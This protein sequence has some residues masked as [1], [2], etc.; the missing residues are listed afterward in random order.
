MCFLTFDK[1]LLKV[2]SK[3]PKYNA[4]VALR[5]KS[6]FFLSIYLLIYSA[7]LGLSCG[8]WELRCHHAGSFVGASELSSCGSWG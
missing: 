6:F 3:L 5:Y 1:S 2:K 4:T 8:I 7:A